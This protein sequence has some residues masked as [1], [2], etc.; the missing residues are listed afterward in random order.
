[1][2]NANVALIIIGGLVA[3]LAVL[4]LGLWIVIQAG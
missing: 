2:T 3:A 1:M 4:G